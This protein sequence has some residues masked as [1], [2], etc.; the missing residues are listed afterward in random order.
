MQEYDNGKSYSHDQSDS[1]ESDETTDAV[2]KRYTEELS[3]RLASLRRADQPTV[4]DDIKVSFGRLRGSVTGYIS[5]DL[6][7]QRIIKRSSESDNNVS[8]PLSTVLFD[9]LAFHAF[10]PFPIPCGSEQQVQIDQD[11]F[12]RAI[13]LLMISPAP[14]YGPNGSFSEAR[15]GRYSGTW[16]PYRGWYIVLR[17]R[18]AG[19][20]RRRMF[21]CLAT[22]LLTPVESRPVDGARFS[23]DEAEEEE[24]PEI[25]VVEDEEEMEVDVVDVLSECPPEVDTLTA[26]PFRESYRLVLSR[27]PRHSGDLMELCVKIESLVKL[28]QL[29]GEV[30]KEGMESLVYE[31]ES[32]S[33]DGVI[34]W[35]DF[36]HLLAKYSEV[37]ADGLLSIFG[38]FAKCGC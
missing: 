14:R 35:P 26:N 6:L 15:Y 36:E 27:L 33:R 9:I 20:F 18:D 38:A 17:G 37:L 21:R 34:G 29:C 12:V 13:C 2:Y 11:G 22:P 3:E 4:I 16:G 5:A 31:I 8:Q 10:Y 24:G 30:Q 25:I 19:D 32:V 7:K 23:Q 1:S 28:V